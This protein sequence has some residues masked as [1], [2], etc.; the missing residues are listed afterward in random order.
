[1]EL[2]VTLNEGP[3]SKVQSDKT[4]LLN[5]SHKL[6]LGPLDEGPRAKIDKLRLILH[7]TI[8][9]GKSNWFE[10][11]K[12]S[13]QFGEP[14]CKLESNSRI[15]FASNKSKLVLRNLNHGP[16]LKWA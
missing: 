13:S 9:E 11:K 15:Q 2:K 6:D 1:M 14:R 8:L 4:I 16:Y 5:K 7:G 12:K 10:P 3:K